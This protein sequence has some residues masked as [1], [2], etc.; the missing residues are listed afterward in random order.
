LWNSPIYKLNHPLSFVG[1]NRRLYEQIWIDVTRSAPTFSTPGRTLSRALK[2]VIKIAQIKEG[3]AILDF[4][5]GKL[6][7]ALHLL[8]QEYKVCAVEFKQLF[9]QSPQAKSLLNEAEMHKPRFSRLVYPHE[10][11]ESNRRFDLA[12][13]INVINVMPVAAERLLVLQYCHQKLRPNSY[14]FW[15]TQRGDADYRKRRVRRY[16]IGDGHYVGKGTKYKTFYREFTVGEIDAL[17]AGAGFEL[18]RAI[19][20]SS[21][22]QARLYRRLEASPLSEVLNAHVIKSARVNDET[23]PEPAEKKPRVIA[24]PRE[25]IVG[26]PD[27]DKLKIPTL[28]IEELKKIPTGALSAYRYQKHVKAMVETL[29]PQELRN[30]TLEV[31]IFGKIKR[32]DIL[33]HNKSRAG[34]FYSLKADHNINCPTIV[35]ECKNYE[36]KLGNPEFD[37]LG[38]RLGKK[39]GMVGILAFR[40]FS[41]RRL[42]MERCRAFFNNEEKIIL[43]IS[44]EDFATMLD[45]KMQ[46]KESEIESFLDN[47]LIEIKVG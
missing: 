40:T 45:L 26:N 38:S 8:E 43:P 30:L 46:S 6:R 17:L 27:P 28:Y 14:L 34:F 18:V 9:D 20:A 21:R 5:A 44:D 47:L 22:N 35:I 37:Q 4:G 1:K 32:L 19:P 7:N 23:I 25:K 31:D 10:F 39:L 13:L 15:Y 41:N 2:K 24:G 42:V 12:L 3:D 29:F 16:E 36:H 33:A 11:K